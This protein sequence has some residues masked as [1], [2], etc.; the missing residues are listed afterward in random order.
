VAADDSFGR[1]SPTT[2][3]FG[4]ANVDIVAPGQ[5]CLSNYLNNTYKSMSEALSDAA[6]HVTAT[7]ALICWL[8]NKLKTAQSNRRPDR[9]GGSKLRGW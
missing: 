4:K 7:V 9:R 1:V 8:A 6:P 2:P 5:Q 3:N